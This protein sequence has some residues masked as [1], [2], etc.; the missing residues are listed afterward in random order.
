MRL[1]FLTI[2]VV[3]GSS[4]GLGQVDPAELAREADRAE[5]EL[6]FAT[7]EVGWRRVLDHG[8]TTRYARRAEARL[9]WLD[10]HRDPD[11]GWAS[12]EALTRARRE[13]RGRASAERFASRVARMPPGRVQRE[14]LVVVAEAYRRA[15]DLPAAL[16]VYDALLAQPDLEA[17]ERRSASVARAEIL[18]AEGRGAEAV[19]VM[20]A[21]RLGDTFEGRELRRVQRA[22]S[23]GAVAWAVA[24]LALVVLVVVGRP[25]RLGVSAVRRVVS[26][27][28][29][30]AGVYVIGVPALIAELY[31]P[32]MAEAFLIFGAGIAPFAVLGLLGAERLADAGR[33]ARTA[34]VGALAAAHVAVAYL[35][36]QATGGLFF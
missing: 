6:D 7:A 24:A 31:E 16:A 21:A 35:A 23:I 29:L 18:A 4:T 1:V 2:V 14:S 17:L 15:G 13:I 32:T 9:A 26:P 5:R 12:L 10:T 3:F 8:P 19:A 20:E 30:L 27:T 34:L 25:W 11:G 33:A 36:L 22:R 28:V